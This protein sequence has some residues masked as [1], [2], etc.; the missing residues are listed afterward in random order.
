MYDW[1][2]PQACQ[3]ET[4]DFSSSEMTEEMPDF[5]SFHCIEH[6]KMKHSKMT[7]R[8]AHVVSLSLEHYIHSLHCDALIGEI[9][10]LRKSA[11]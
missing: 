11:S 3:A 10:V 6:Q 2:A 9:V 5:V 8:V 4:R 7:Q 1:I